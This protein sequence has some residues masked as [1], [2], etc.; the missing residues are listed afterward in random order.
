MSWN[1]NSRLNNLQV[2]VNQLTASSVENPLTSSLNCSSYPIIGAT[3]ITATTAQN[4]N[5]NASNGYSIIANAPLLVPNHQIVV[6]NN[7]TNDGLIVGDNV[8]DDS[9]FRV[10]ASGN[11][12]IKSEPASSLTADF[13]VNGDAL[14]TG[15]L[16]VQNITCASITAPIVNAGNVVNNITAGSGITKTGTSTNPTLTNSGILAL[17]AGS[18]I[19]LTGTNANTTVANSGILALTAGTGITLSGTNSNITIN[20]VIPGSENLEQ[21]LTVGN[22]ANGLDIEGVD[23]LQ[24]NTISFDYANSGVFSIDGGLASGGSGAGRLFDVS[25]SSIT[26]ALTTAGLTVDTFSFSL[27]PSI[28]SSIT[29][30]N[31]IGIIELPNIAR[32]QDFN[33]NINVSS[34]TTTGNTIILPPISSNNVNSLYTIN[35]NETSGTGNLSIEAYNDNM[36]ITNSGSG[37]YVSSITLYNNTPGKRP[38]I[39]LRSI[40]SPISSL[41]VSF[42][43]RVIFSQL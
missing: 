25:A 37:D 7:T 15:D 6:L 38:F 10:D 2:Q 29:Y 3:N 16:D 17:T 5:L 14:L 35:L 34:L 39:Q 4:L 12:A 9:V 31:S 36:I 18:G 42:C 32:T 33:L 23:A 22:D 28:S 21:V 19:T 13:T 40:T 41:S 43:W 11:V 30:N 27:N 1:F 26:T 24:T 20:A 8:S